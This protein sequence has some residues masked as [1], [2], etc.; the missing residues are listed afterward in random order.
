[1]AALFLH[2]SDNYPLGTQRWTTGLKLQAQPSPALIAH[3]WTIRWRSLIPS[4]SVPWASFSISIFFLFSV[5][6]PNL[7]SF[8]Q[9]HPLF[10]CLLILI[11]IILLACHCCH[12]HICC[13][14]HTFSRLH[15]FHFEDFPRSHLGFPFPTLIPINSL[16]HFSSSYPSFCHLLFHVFRV[17]SLRLYLQRA[18]EVP[19]HWKSLMR[20]RV[21]STHS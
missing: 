14:N 11:S 6:I 21:S 16:K 19:E 13:P 3:L 12:L 20:A 10:P 8:F 7:F 1:M 4:T 9:L 5:G 18:F 17:H 15:N 2:T